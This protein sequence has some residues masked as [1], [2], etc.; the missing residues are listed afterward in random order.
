[1][2]E[3]EEKNEIPRSLPEQNFFRAGSRFSAKNATIGARQSLF[4]LTAISESSYLSAE[5]FLERDA[6]T[7]L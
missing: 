3:K 5:R 1:M 4:S 7:S 2:F 6:E